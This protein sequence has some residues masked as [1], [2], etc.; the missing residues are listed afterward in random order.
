MSSG[1]QHTRSA[2]G[3]L[4]AIQLYQAAR[5]ILSLWFIASMWETRSVSPA[6]TSL[7]NPFSPTGKFTPSWGTSTLTR[8]ASSASGKVKILSGIYTSDLRHLCGDTPPPCLSWWATNPTLR[9]PPSPLSPYLRNLMLVTRQGTE[10]GTI[11]KQF[12]L[13]RCISP[14]IPKISK[15]QL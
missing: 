12:N 9:K 14:D 4:W 5:Q 7:P 3:G 10:G 2:M 6:T 15:V 13:V 8:S 1:K 11:C